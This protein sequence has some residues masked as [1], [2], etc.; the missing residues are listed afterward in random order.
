MDKVKTNERL[1]NINKKTFISV[2]VLLFLLI[3]FSMVLTYVL[4]KGE[5][6]PI[7]L[8][9]AQLDAESPLSDGD[10]LSLKGKAGFIKVNFS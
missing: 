9:G 8:N 3:V 6:E 10:E 4:P 7:W 2:F 1:I 5:Y